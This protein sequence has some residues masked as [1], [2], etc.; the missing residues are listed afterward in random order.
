DEL[1]ARQRRQ[2]C[3]AAVRRMARSL[4]AQQRDDLASMSSSRMQWYSGRT[5]PGYVRLDPNPLELTR[6]S[7]VKYEDRWQISRI[8]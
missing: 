4:T 2:D 8:E 1:A 7:F 6:I 3:P 5:G